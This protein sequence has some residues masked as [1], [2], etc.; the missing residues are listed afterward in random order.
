MCLV[1]IAWKQHP[2]LPLIV[3][4]NRDEFHARPTKEAHWWND[5]PSILGGR[6]LQAGG[7]WLGLHRTGRFAAVTN[8]RDA[9]TRPAKLR[10]R[11]H[12]VT[13]FLDSESTPEEFLTSIVGAD[14]AGFNLLLS[15]GESLAWYSNRSGVITALGPGIYGQSNALLDAPWHKVVRAKESLKSLIDSDTVNESE[16]FRLLDNREKAPVSQVDSDRLPFETAHAISSAF[17]VLPD[18]GTRNSSIA[19]RDKTGGWNFRERRFDSS[20][21]QTGES[22]FRFTPQPEPLKAND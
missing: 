7:T 1:I 22:A 3:A 18:Y 9:D 2:A 16:L 15:D 12:L 6:D 14:Y 19:L 4:A 5:Q 20:G 10:S 17:I 13:D 21:V 8:F 11:G